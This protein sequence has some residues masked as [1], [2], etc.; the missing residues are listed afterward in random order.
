MFPSHDK[1]NWYEGQGFIIEANKGKGEDIVHHS[2]AKRGEISPSDVTISSPL[3]LFA[4]KMYGSMVARAY[5][6]YFPL[7][8]ENKAITSY[9]IQMNRAHNS[10]PDHKQNLQQMKKSKAKR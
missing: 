6:I 1:L 9:V 2:G 7:L 3:P 4:S 10:Q 5:I 8:L